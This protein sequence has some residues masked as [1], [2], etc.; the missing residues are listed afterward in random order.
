M[1]YHENNRWTQA[2]LSLRIMEDHAWKKCVEAYE[3]TLQKGEN[4]SLPEWLIREKHIS[5][6]QLSSI[7]EY[8]Q[9]SEKTMVTNDSESFSVGKT[10]IVARDG[11]RLVS[12]AKEA[13]AKENDK[14]MGSRAATLRMQPKIQSRSL[15][16]IGRYQIIKEI[17]QGG[18]GKVYLAYDTELQREVAIKVLLSG[19][20]AGSVEI[21]RFLREARA[22]RKSVV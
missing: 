2:I 8:C 15:E 16:R 22:D 5:G 4:L 20:F 7:E 6:E 13:G 1:E 18:M 3:E 17:G 19:A 10:H 21:E 14:V 11:Q 12:D 9:V